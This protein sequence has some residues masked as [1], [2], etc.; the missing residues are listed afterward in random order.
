MSGFLAKI[1]HG[2]M[3]I[4][5]HQTDLLNVHATVLPH[6]LNKFCTSRAKL[7]VCFLS[8][9]LSYFDVFQSIS[10]RFIRIFFYGFWGGLKSGTS[11]H[12][13]SGY[14]LPATEA[15]SKHDN[16]ILLFS[17]S[18]IKQI[19]SP[20]FLPSKSKQ[21]QAGTSCT[22]LTSGL[23][24]FLGL[25]HHQSSILDPR[26]SAH[27]PRSPVIGPWSSVPNPRSS[28]LG[29][30]SSVFSPQSSPNLKTLQVWCRNAKNSLCFEIYGNF[31][32][33]T[34]GNLYCKI[35]IEN[36]H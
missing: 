35:V 3:N 23:R 33:S 30:Q 17:P 15:K 32:S 16:I 34:F 18:K 2:P 11:P 4:H 25:K 10:F 24:G 1:Q 31:F 22:K 20:Y 13:V 28:F 7:F 21:D 9:F 12:Y 8:Q 36:E 26:S 5:P 27:N 19:S 6:H 29:P 14:W